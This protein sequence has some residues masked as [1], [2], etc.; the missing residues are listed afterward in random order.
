MKKNLTMLAIIDGWGINEK[1]EG[2]AVNLANKPNLYSIFSQYPT[3]KIKKNGV[4][5]CRP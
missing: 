2:K 1:Q 5:C 3:N 4:D